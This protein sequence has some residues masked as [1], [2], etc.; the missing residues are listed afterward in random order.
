[1]SCTVIGDYHPDIIILVPW[2]VRGGA[3]L[4]VLHHADAALA[5]GKKV[6]VIA[7]LDAESP[8][9]E[10]LPQTARF[11]ELGKIG[12]NLS[13]QQRLTV[14]TRLVLQSPARVVH[15]IN[16]RLGWEMIKTYGKSLRAVGKTAVRQRLL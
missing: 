11:V 3:D 8:W 15:I 10:R 9:K 4:G 1:M 13:E 14:L 12:R 16:S 5:A 6:L 7:T 2:L